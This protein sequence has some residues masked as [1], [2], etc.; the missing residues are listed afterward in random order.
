MLTVSLSVPTR[1]PLYSPKSHVIIITLQ[2]TGLPF[3]H[4]WCRSQDY[5]ERA[6]QHGQRCQGRFC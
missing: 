3:G 2:Q 4:Y 5:E 1:A 6:Q